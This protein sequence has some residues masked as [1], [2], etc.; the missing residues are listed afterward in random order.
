MDTL[1]SL[2]STVADT[3]TRQVA[4]QVKKAMDMAGS[5]QSVPGNP[6]SAGMQALHSPHG[7][8]QRG[9]VERSTSPR[10][11]AGAQ[12]RSPLPDP[13]MEKLQS[14][15]LP[16]LPMRHTLGGPH[17]LKS[18]NRLLGLRTPPP[19]DEECSTEVVATIMG[20]YAEELTQMAWKAQLR[21]AQ[22]VLA[23]E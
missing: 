6:P 16:P 19:R 9:S 15:Q 1:K 8:W 7:T 22:Q 17:G 3:I 4:E 11:A 2:M 20:G 12:R 14:Q 18:T 23:V 5:A 10:A 13:H 21:S